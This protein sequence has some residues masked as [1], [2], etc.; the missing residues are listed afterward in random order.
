MERHVIVVSVDAMV[1]EDIETLSKLSAFRDLWPSTARVNRV[2]SVYPT[3]TYPC[4]STMQT[5]L[6]PDKHGILNNEQPIMCEKSSLWQ[7]MRNMVHGKNIFDYAKEKGLTTAAVFWPVSGNDPSIDYL[8]AEYWPQTPEETSEECYVNSGSSPEV[9]EKVVKPNLPYVENRQRQHPYC[10]AFVMG[11]ACSMVREFKPNLLM[12]HPANVDAYRHETGLFTEKVTQAL[13]ETNQWMVE[14]FK[15]CE[16]AGILDSTDFF[17]VSDHGQLNVSRCIALNVKLA[18]AGLIDVAEDGSVRD[19]KAFC[20]S[21]GL[22]ALVYLKDPDNKADYEATKALLDKLCAEEVYGISRVFTRE[23]A[24][25]EEHLSGPFAFVLETDGY[26]SF[27]NDWQRPLVKILDNQNYRFGRATHGHLPHKGPQPTMFAFGPHIQ[28]GV[29]LE[30][31]RLVDEA[32][33]FAKVLGIEMKDIDG[34]CLSELL[35]EGDA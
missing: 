6:Y 3:I 26:T 9:M 1:Y 8:V 35:R 27:S 11:C 34:R 22:S 30:E 25:A 20:K 7:H 10:D 31:A 2:R 12:V 18:E 32:P 23:E 15:A 16:D 21:G 5:G 4:H 13:Y 17:I 28:P 33:T 19:W 29:V 24:E 14:L